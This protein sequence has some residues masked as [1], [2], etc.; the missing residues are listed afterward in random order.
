MN[1][2]LNDLSSMTSHIF[3]LSFLYLIKFKKL[4][5]STAYPLLYSIR[6]K[7]SG[8]TMHALHKT[9]YK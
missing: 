9:D 2:H 8:K 3:G 1:L 5:H 4:L 6:N 7:N